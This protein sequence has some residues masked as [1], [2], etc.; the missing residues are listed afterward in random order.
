M[1]KAVATI[2]G[3]HQDGVIR[4]TIEPPGK[5]DEVDVTDDLL[6]EIAKLGSEGVTGSRAVR[7][8]VKTRG[9]DVDAALNDL[10]SSGLVGRFKAGRAWVYH[11]TD[12][13]MFAV[14]QGGD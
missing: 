7:A 3:V 1:G 10:L 13:G 5:G 14:E 8:L 2:T 11:A 6:W 4:Y 12:E 9:K